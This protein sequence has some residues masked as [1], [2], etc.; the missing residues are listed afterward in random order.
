MRKNVYKVIAVLLASM[1]LASCGRAETEKGA[2]TEQNSQEG[3]S[4]SQG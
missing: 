2:E 1:M 3:N 4:M